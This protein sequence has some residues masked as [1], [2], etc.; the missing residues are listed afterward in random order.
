MFLGIVKI[1]ISQG[2]NGFPNDDVLYPVFSNL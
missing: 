2:F 1:Y